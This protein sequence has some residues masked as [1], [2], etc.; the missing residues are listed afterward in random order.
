VS[1]ANAGLAQDPRERTGPASAAALTSFPSGLQTGE[2]D[3]K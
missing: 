1:C 2:S 3:G